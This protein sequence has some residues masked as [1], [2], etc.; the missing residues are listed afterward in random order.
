MRTAYCRYSQ[1]SIQIIN[2]EIQFFSCGA[3]RVMHDASL[4]KINKIESWMEKYSFGF[5]QEAT[6]MGMIRISKDNRSSCHCC[7]SLC[8]NFRSRIT[9]VNLQYISWSFHIFWPYPT[10]MILNWISYLNQKVQ[11]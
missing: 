1:C 11:T 8:C 6:R 4:E 10:L 2:K 3:G 5:I 7:C 9:L